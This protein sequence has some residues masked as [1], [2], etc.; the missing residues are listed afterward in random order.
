MTMT[1]RKPFKKAPRI[2]GVIGAARVRARAKSARRRATEK[3][4]QQYLDM[5]APPPS[6]RQASIY[7]EL[8]RITLTLD[9]F[10][11]ERLKTIGGGSASDGARRLA[12][13]SSDQFPGLVAPKVEP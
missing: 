12:R 9:A 10:T 6:S 3:Q 4:S 7:G 1:A 2:S 13:L 8:F 11:I 5:A